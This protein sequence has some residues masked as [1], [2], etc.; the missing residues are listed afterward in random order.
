[1]VSFF[2]TIAISLLSSAFLSTHRK[3]RKTELELSFQRFP[4]VWRRHCGFYRGFYL[5][6]FVRFI[7]KEGIDRALCIYKSYYTTRQSRSI[8]ELK[9]NNSL[10]VNESQGNLTF[11]LHFWLLFVAFPCRFCLRAKGV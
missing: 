4:L 3:E 11:F 2:L 6:T 8:A 9:Q 7:L 5:R 10:L 1:M